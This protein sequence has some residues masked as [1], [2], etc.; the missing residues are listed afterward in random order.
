[1]V[2][3]RRVLTSETMMPGD[4]IFI[5]VEGPVSGEFIKVLVCFSRRLD[6]KKTVEFDVIE[7]VDVEPEE[8]E[9]KA[10]DIIEIDWKN[11]VMARA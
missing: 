9:Y 1:M 7:Q 5:I 6:D 2:D 10:G 4:N 11:I 8:A 3:K